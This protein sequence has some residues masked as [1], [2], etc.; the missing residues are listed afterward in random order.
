MTK[1]EDVYMLDINTILDF[2]TVSDIMKR[3]YTRIPVFENGKE[4]VVALLNIKD[5]A[6]IDP[7]D[8]T[9]MRTVIKF[10]QHPLVFV[11]DDQ[12]LDS[13][14]HEFRQGK[15]IALAI[16]NTTCLIHVMMY[17]KGNER[18]CMYS[19]CTTT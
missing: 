10:Y 13:M 16:P 17:Q 2:E 8:K 5:L 7:D 12:K 11:F 19:T 1:I 6:L 15:G 4:N 18:L 3:G 9:A 14:L